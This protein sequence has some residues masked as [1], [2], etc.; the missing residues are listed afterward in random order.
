MFFVSTEQHSLSFIETSA[1]DSTNIEAAFRNILTGMYEYKYVPIQ[2]NCTNCTIILFTEIYNYVQFEKLKGIS[3]YT[4][5]CNTNVMLIFAEYN[6]Q[7]NVEH[8]C[9]IT[10]VFHNKS[11]LTICLANFYS[12]QPTSYSKQWENIAQTGNL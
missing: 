3:F 12:T 4:Q 6:V 5:M 7:M 10:S 1:L 8:Y 9:A 2:I 11:K